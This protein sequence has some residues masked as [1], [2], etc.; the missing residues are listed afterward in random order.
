MPDAFIC[1]TVRTPIGRYGAET[2][3]S[4]S[5]RYAYNHTEV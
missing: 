2:A 5:P 4:Q 3:I 1:D